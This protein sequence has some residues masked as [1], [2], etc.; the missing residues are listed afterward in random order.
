MRR[1]PGRPSPVRTAPLPP[2]AIPESAEPRRGPTICS[3]GCTGQPAVHR[4]VASNV[5]S[6]PNVDLAG[7]V[8]AAAGRGRLEIVPAGRG[9]GRPSRRSANPDSRGGRSPRRPLEP[10][11]SWPGAIGCLED[12]H[13]PSPAGPGPTRWQS[14]RSPGADH[15]AAAVG[16]ARARFI[17]T[18]L[19]ASC[20]KVPQ[21][22]IWRQSTSG[23][24]VSTHPVHDRHPGRR[25]PRARWRK[26]SPPAGT[27]APAA[28]QRGS[29][30]RWLSRGGPRLF[31][32]SR[33]RPVV[34]RLVRHPV[35]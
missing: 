12:H 9:S 7:D 11:R 21:Y 15:D 32:G 29:A 27:P 4:Q 6:S 19:R 34:A 24:D 10:E 23:M 20:G 5:A 2:R 25:A 35:G 33:H 31:H 3:T 8:Q 28:R 1:R 30:Q 26:G 18:G 13:V 17:G 14:P 16:R 22:A